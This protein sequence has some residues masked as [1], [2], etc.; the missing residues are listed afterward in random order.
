M[1][2]RGQEGKLAALQR[3]EASLP[4]VVLGLDSG[5]RGEFL[6]YHM[7]KRLQK[8]PQPDFMTRSRP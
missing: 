3:M 1:W 7:L 8:C 6:N 2:G 5:N 4:L